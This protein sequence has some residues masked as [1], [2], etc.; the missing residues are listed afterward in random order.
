MKNERENMAIIRTKYGKANQSQSFEQ[1]K[2]TFS[3][4]FKTMMAG[5]F[6]E[7]NI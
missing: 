6:D 1:S 4:L 2:S 3:I 5:Y 7:K